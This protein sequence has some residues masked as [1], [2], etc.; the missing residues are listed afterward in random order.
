MTLFARYINRL[1]AFRLAMVL[2][3]LVALA[4]LLDMM[5]H[6]D[7][8]VAGDGVG[9]LWRYFALRLPVIASK[10]LPFSVL[11]AALLTL[12]SLARHG[13]LVVLLGAGVSPW[14][15]VLAFL[16]AVALLGL[17]H[18]WLDD[19]AVPPATAEL[20]AW[21]ASDYGAT[22]A[23]AGRTWLRDGNDVIRLDTGGGDDKGGDDRGADDQGRLVGVTIFQ[24]DNDGILVARLDAASAVIEDGAWVLHDVARYQVAGNRVEA[25][26]RLP[27]AGNLRPAL[28]ATLRSHPR[29]LSL[30]Q[31]RR[32]LAAPGFASRPLY[33]YQTWFNRKLVAPLASLLMILIAVPLSQRFQRHGGAATTLALGI[34]IGFCFF[35]FDGFTL[36]VA[37]AG[38]VPPLIAAWAPTLAF[39]AVGA[40]LGFHV[41]RR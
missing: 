28:L 33:V 22:V 7:E 40:A 12:V 23:A 32:Y 19:G 6:A 1:F 10:L 27:W 34:V 2:A 36:T 4:S 30:T 20:R 5:A 21:A 13:E 35:V 14:R 9:A 38:L 16:P 37:E 11:I 41:E 17:V 39:A 8:V 18:F 3:G 31:V 15:L 26:A 29:E 24:R 25:I